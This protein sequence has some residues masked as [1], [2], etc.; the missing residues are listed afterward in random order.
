MRVPPEAGKLRAADTRGGHMRILWSGLALHAVMLM[1]A[2]AQE[3]V[4][5]SDPFTGIDTAT[6]AVPD[7]HFTP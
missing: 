6:I 1:P 2:D 7:L 4:P 5:S 3:A